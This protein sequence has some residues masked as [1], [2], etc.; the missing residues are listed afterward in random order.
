[1][2]ILNNK[3]LSINFILICFFVHFPLIAF[4]DEGINPS[5]N[6]SGWI[7]E[8][9]SYYDD[10]EGSDAVQISD[11]GTTLGSRITFSG[12]ATLPGELNAGFDVTIEPFSGNPNFLDGIESGQITP[13]VFSN[14]DNLDSFNGGDIGLLG[15]SIFIGG[16]WGKVTIGL[17]SMPTDNIGVLGD[18]SMTIWS[19]VGALFRGSGF[20]IRGAEGAGLLEG[21]ATWG[22]F[23]QCMTLNGLGIGIDCNG[24]YR[25]GVRYDLPAF[26]PV[27]IAVGYANDDI[28]DIAAKYSDKVGDMELRFHVGYAYNA[29]GG[30]NVAERTVTTVAGVD[31]GM[32]AGGDPVLVDVTSVSLGDTETEMLT[33]QMG[34][35]DTATGLFGSFTWQHEEASGDVSE[36]AEDENNAYYTKL[37]IRKRWNKL[38][39][40]AFYA[41]YG[42]YD[43]QYSA[44]LGEQGV[45]GSKLTRTGMA[46]EQYF[47]SKMIVYMKYEQ[48]DVDV[49]G[50][51]AVEE[52]YDD[53]D[54]LNLFSMGVTYFF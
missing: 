54:E 28:Y 10:G 46:L 33:M 41:E 35:M 12:S 45:T 19:G 29:D 49:E 17:Q 48:L 34:L 30:A 39:D 24:V 26:G 44:L 6:I 52:I 31:T 37:G 50:T 16:S 3:K 1:M 9:I 40:T 20:F 27:S 23:A 25:N 14:Q 38:G 32:T 5:W 42:Q 15:S 7:N 51:D 2:I 8:S 18:P 21:G 53:V 43:D 36:F 4:S 11:N 47:G 22:S 13:L